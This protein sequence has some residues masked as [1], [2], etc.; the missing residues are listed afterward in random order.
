MNLVAVREKQ[1]SSSKGDQGHAELC[2]LRFTNYELR[3]LKK[4]TKQQIEIA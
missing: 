2:I 1:G 4:P 3:E